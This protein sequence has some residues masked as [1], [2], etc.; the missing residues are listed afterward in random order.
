[1]VCTVCWGLLLVCLVQ[2][3]PFRPKLGALLHPILTSDLD[4]WVVEIVYA[5]LLVAVIPVVALVIGSS[6]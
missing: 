3:N 1:M 6:L 5:V 4:V 2:I